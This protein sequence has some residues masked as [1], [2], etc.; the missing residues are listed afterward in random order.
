MNQVMIETF[1][2][3]T[4][5]EKV[6]RG[7]GEA[8]AGKV[9]NYSHCSFSVKGVG[10][11]RPE[12]GAKPTLGKLGKLE[13]VDEERITMQC[14]RRLLKQVISAIKEAH[15]YEEAPIFVCSLMN[16]DWHTGK[17]KKCRLNSV[18]RVPLS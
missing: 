2:P 17:R 3:E 10:R 7:M 16:A 13:E 8:G 5:A 11:F 18:G 6:R 14:E 9:G 12:S 4:H 1:V 15:P